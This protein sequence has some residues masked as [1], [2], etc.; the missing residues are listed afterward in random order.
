VISKLLKNGVTITAA[1]PSPPKNQKLS[2]QIFV[3]TG[4]LESLPREEAKQKIRSLGGEISESVSK[5]T[6]FV[7]AGENPGS[8]LDKARQLG[9]K[10]ITE[11]EFLEVIK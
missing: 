5:K 9:V 11:K 1:L 4:T 10:I 8:K 7:I 2:G 3:L 6:S